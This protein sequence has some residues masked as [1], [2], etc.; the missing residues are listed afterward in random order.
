MPGKPGLN[1]DEMHYIQHN[2]KGFHT[3]KWYKIQE[4]RWVMLTIAMDG[5]VYRLVI[6]KGYGYPDEFGKPR[7]QKPVLNEVRD[8]LKAIEKVF[9]R[10]ISEIEY[11]YPE[12]RKNLEL[13]AQTLTLKQLGGGGF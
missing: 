4:R 9:D 7:I 8:N 1:P 11:R 5:K 2:S 3:R 13:Q 10:C 6:T 12:F